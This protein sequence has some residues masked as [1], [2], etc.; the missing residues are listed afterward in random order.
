MSLKK[1]KKNKKKN[2]EIT[3]EKDRRLNLL[4]MRNSQNHVSRLDYITKYIPPYHAYPRKKDSTWEMRNVFDLIRRLN[5]HLQPTSKQM[6][7]SVSESFEQRFHFP[8]PAYS[9]SHGWRYWNRTVDGLRPDLRP[10]ALY[11]CTFVCTCTNCMNYVSVASKQL[12]V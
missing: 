10:H 7:Q 6:Q 4:N 12:C 3:P 5:K 11:V 1:N 9:S 8:F 2:R